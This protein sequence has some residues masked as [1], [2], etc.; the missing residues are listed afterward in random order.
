MMTKNEV[1]ELKLTR[2]EMHSVRIVNYTSKLMRYQEEV[3]V[4]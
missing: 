4:Q 2:K 3:L 1:L